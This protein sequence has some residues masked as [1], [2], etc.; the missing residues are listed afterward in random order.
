MPLDRQ[1]V[2]P[3]FSR[4]TTLGAFTLAIAFGLWVSAGR[5]AAQD[6]QYWAASYGT[7]SRLLG[8]TVIANDPDI[9]S[10]YYNPGA[11][12]LEKNVQLL[13]SLNALQ[14][15]TLSFSSSQV[16]MKIPTNSSWSALPNMFAG[17]IRIGGKNSPQR[18]AYSL[19]T[20]QSY[21]FGAQI[22]ALPLDSFAPP[23]PAPVTS[24][25]GNARS[26]PVTE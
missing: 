8:G 2:S 25:V 20:R 9:S 6:T 12:A 3:S 11:L 10:V 23:P 7:Q 16:P 18:L 21:N 14:Y 19:L 26:Q 17:A 24:S 22:R 13:V 5:L 1:P 15:S 4:G